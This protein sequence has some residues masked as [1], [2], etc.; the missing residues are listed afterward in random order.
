MTG[1]VQPSGFLT[2]LWQEVAR[3]HR[4]W[5]LDSVLLHN[6]VTKMM[7]DVAT[8]PPKGVYMQV[9]Y[10]DWDLHKCRLSDGAVLFTH[11]PVIHLYAVHCRDPK[12]Y[13]YPAYKCAPT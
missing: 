13:S 3:A 4:G 6:E 7:E 12:L 10:L 1:L 8:T 11:L 9:L 5:A 2:V